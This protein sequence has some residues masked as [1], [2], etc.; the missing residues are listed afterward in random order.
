[1]KKL[2]FLII[3]IALFAILALPA[4]ATPTH[5]NNVYNADVT[6]D[7]ELVLYLW[8]MWGNEKYDDSHWT[9]FSYGFGDFLEIGGSY[10]ITE[11][12]DF[13]SDPHFDAR[14]RYALADF[15]K[16]DE[17]EEGGCAEEEEGGEGEGGCGEGEGGVC[18]GGA[19]SYV[20]TTGI[21]IGIDNLTGDEDVNGNMIPYIA[22]THDF[23]DNFRGTAGYAFEDGNNAIFVGF[24]TT[25]GSGTYKWDW[26]QINDGADW[27]AS[28]GFEFPFEAYWDNWAI[29][30]WLSFSSNQNIGEVWIVEVSYLI[31]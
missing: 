27:Q 26:R 18:C 13:R 22:Y 12:D 2:L 7:G 25:S 20:N 10:R 24:D 23:G 21:A 6:G 1:M 16:G 3:P 11:N 15:W 14:L 9:G 30:S 31:D 8:G 5:T 19:C 29:A 28:V 4:M 17:E